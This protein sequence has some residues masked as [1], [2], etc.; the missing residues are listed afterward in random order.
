VRIEQP[1]D[2]AGS[3]EPRLVRKHRR[4]FEGFDDKIVTLY[5]RGVTVRDIQVRLR[6][7]YELD[8]GHD[9]ISRVT[10]A[11][12]EDVAAWQVRPLQA[13]YPIV[14]VDCL[15]LKVIS[16]VFSQSRPW[17]LPGRRS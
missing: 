1:R 9:L 10:D 11:V 7:L 14:Y 15:V 12:L 3:F 17:T 5:S 8:V 16:D 4:R 13:V 6:E 2:R